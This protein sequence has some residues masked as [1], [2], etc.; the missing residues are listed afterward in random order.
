MLINFDRLLYIFG[1]FKTEYYDLDENNCMICFNKCIKFKCKYIY[2][3][4]VLFLLSLKP[5]L[6]LHYILVTENTNYLLS[7]VLFSLVSPVNYV[8]GFSYISNNH[9]HKVFLDII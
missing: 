8:L 9:F 6:I 3:I 2:S 1:I 7:S 4:F 5:I